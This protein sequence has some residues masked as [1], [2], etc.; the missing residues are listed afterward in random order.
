MAFEVIEP[1]H[2][3][4]VKAIESG[5][6]RLRPKGELVLRADD[7][8]AVGIEHFA[9][10]MADPATLRIGLRAVDDG[11]EQQ[12]MSVTVITRGKSKTD[13]GRR[14]ISVNRAIKHVGLTPDAVAGSF[15]LHKR[16]DGLLTINLTE[17]RDELK[18][19]G[20]PK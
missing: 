16:G 19:P 18:P 3:I 12:S 8:Q 14:R 17:G 5:E 20:D 1:G 4:P 15:K 7:L 6:C 10:V 11:E 2:F 13:S 9:I